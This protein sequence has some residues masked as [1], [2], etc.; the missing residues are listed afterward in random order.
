MYDFVSREESSVARSRAH[1]LISEVRANLNQ[2]YTFQNTLVGSAAW[3]TIIRDENGY[4]LDYQLILTHNSPIFSDAKGLGKPSTIKKD[5]IGSFSRF[6]VK[7]EKLYDSTTAITLIHKENG[8]QL[9]SIDFVII[10]GTGDRYQIIRRNNNKDNP[11]VNEYTWNM[12]KNA[13]KAYEIFNNLSDDEQQDVIRKV[14][15]AKI[16]EKMK[17]DNDKTKKTSS[18]ILAEEVMKYVNSQKDH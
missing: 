17:D 18:Q 2:K 14:I 7:N 9:F 8:K 13:P 16:T 4:D 3:N 5:F 10:D 6:L 15:A 11:S 1:A 12:L